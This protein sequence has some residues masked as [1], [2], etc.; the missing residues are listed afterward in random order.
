MTQPAVPLAIPD[1]GP[2]EEAEVLEVLRTGRLALGPKNR[3]FERLVSGFTGSAWGTAVSSGTSGLHLAFRAVGVGADDCVVTSSF[4]FVA[5]ANAFAY[6]GAA[7]VFL[8]IDPE[9]LAISTTALSDYLGSCKERDGALHDPDTGRRVG[10]VEPV[11]IF[12]HPVHLDRIRELTDPWGIAVV[13]DS[14]EALGSRWRRDDGTWVHA[15]ATADAAAFAFYPNK[16]ITTGEGGMVV[17]ADPAV[18]DQV[19][20]QRNQG[21]RPGDAWLFHTRLG[22]NYRM[23]ELQ[24]AV[25]VAQMRRIDE[26]LARRAVVANWYAEALADVHEVTTPA[27]AEWAKPALFVMHLRVAD[28]IDRDRLVERMNADGVETKAYF[29]PPIHRQPV[30]A[31]RTECIPAPLLETERASSNRLIVPFFGTMTRDQVDRVAV[32]LRAA[33]GGRN[34]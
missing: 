28:G 5:S 34:T 32:T 24:A 3:E 26:L 22:F 29:E 25:G 1:I 13:S 2:A 23:S 12:G 4:S 16:Q 33:L 31:G 20:S 14:C 8:D 30:Y 17:G 27:H 6:E 18:E 11:D 10:A 15:G 7:P 21:R 19:V 9:T